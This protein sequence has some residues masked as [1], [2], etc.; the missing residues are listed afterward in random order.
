MR[1]ITSFAVNTAP[2]AKLV[3]ACVLAGLIGVGIAF[4]AAV[5]TGRTSV[6][7]AG[8]ALAHVG[9]EF[10]AAAPPLVNFARRRDRLDHPP[11]RAAKADFL[12]DLVDPPDHSQRRLKTTPV[13]A[14]VDDVP[15]RVASFAPTEARLQS[16]A[17]DIGTGPVS[18]IGSAFDGAMSDG[19][20]RALDA[21]PDRQ[22][23]NVGRTAAGAA[24]SLSG[25]AGRATGA[26]GF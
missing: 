17:E 14:V 19:T 5:L 10:E 6:S 23:R 24:G 4:L 20:R 22:S 2:Q 13:M 1:R 9:V 21:L 26:L 25:A 3:G 16:A 12:A 18:L 15:R 8:L 7:E 11:H